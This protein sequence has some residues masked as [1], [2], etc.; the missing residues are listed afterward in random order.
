MLL[1]FLDVA[2]DSPRRL[3]NAV[4]CARL[5]RLCTAHTSA[6]FTPEA[7]VQNPIAVDAIAVGEQSMI[8]GELLVIPHSGH[9]S[10]GDWCYVGPG[11]KIW[12]M[13]SVHIGDR[14]FISHGVQIFDNNSHSLSAGERHDRYRELRTVGRH[15]KQEQVT[16]KAVIIEDDVWL[17]FNVAVMKGVTVGRGA[18]VGACAVVVDDVAPFSVVV[19]NPARQVG[20]SRQ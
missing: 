14:V 19:G 12:S 17:G 4:R 9:I 5:K 7:S 18:V 8:M 13:S 16:A 10:I 15:L 3:R 20:N 6:T 11:S 1:R 2:L